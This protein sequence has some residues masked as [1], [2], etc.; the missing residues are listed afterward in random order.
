MA[1]EAGAATVP[2]P[3]LE[4]RGLSVEVGA[5]RVCTGL[6]FA[7]RAGE[8][9]GLLGANGSGKTTLLHTLA[10]LRAPQA[11]EVRLDGLL[12]VKDPAV[13]ARFRADPMI[14]TFRGGIDVHAT[15]EQLEHIATLIPADWLRHAATG[16]PAQ[17]VAAIRNQRALGCDG[18]IL[19]GAAPGELLP[20]VEAYRTTA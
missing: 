8:R 4:A 1:V 9:W 6:G 11:G 2:A 13:L 17:C 19:H 7:L 20:I 15:T 18:V 12:L 10:G 5:H 14:S 3:L 16:S